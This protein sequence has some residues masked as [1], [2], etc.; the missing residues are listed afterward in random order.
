MLTVDEATEHD[1]FDIA[2]L[3][4]DVDEFY[5]DPVTEE[6][7]ARVDS[8]ELALFSSHP[9]ARVLLAHIEGQ[10]AGLAALSYLWPAAGSTS[11][12]YLK[13]L[14][15]RD[16]FRG[17]G[18]GEALFKRV[19]EI[20]HDLGFSRVELTTDRDNKN[21]QQFYER[22]GVPMNTNKIV[23]RIPAEMIRKFI[24]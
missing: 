8:I 22:L 9:S 3:L 4:N 11:S 10:T 23:Y 24:E 13:E 14:Y 12:I 2:L 7:S 19:C 15:V 21:A 6:V 17:Q 1:L 5:G 18:V 20:A 16:A